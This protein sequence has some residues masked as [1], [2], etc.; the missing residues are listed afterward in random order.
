MDKLS[1]PAAR[2]RNR[3]LDE[4][5]SQLDS[6]V[7][8]YV[9]RLIAE[10]RQLRALLRERAE[11]PQEPKCQHGHAEYVVGCVSCVLLHQRQIR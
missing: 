6:T 1:D 5:E 2:E 8:Y 9:P 11:P 7:P 4:I 3:D 10:L